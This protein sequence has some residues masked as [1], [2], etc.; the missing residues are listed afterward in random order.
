MATFSINGIDDCLD[1]FKAMLEG[2]KDLANDMLLAEADIVEDKQKSVGR[3][4]G[5]Y[6]ETSNIHVVNKIGHTKI[7]KDSDGYKMFVYPQGKRTRNGITTTNS[8]IAFINEYGKS[9]QPARPFITTANAQAEA[10]AIDAAEKVYDN[11]LKK[12]E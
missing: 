9:G 11:W 5:V 7:K 8:E 6:D 4:M 12:F 1:D 2:G 3:S 10:K